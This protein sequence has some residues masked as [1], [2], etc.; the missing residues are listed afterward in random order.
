MERLTSP[1]FVMKKYEIEAKIKV[2]CLEP[3]AR[4]LAELHADALPMVWEEDIY[5][6]NAEGTLIRGDC[7]LRLRKR[8]TKGKGEQ[9]ILTFKGARQASAFK[10]RLETE[11]IVADYEAMRNI[12]E[13]LGCREHLRVEK[14][15]HRWQLDNCEICL[16]D[17][18]PLGQFVEIEGPNEAAVA[19]VLQKLGL[20]PKDHISEGY[21]RMMARKL[22]GDK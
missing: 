19:E 9:F 1:V 18:P 2:D 4:R 7:G 5:F 6:D 12:L 14:D 15:R 10:S 17:V 3:V 8:I 20:N 22:F 16:D 13:Q 11:T 21:A